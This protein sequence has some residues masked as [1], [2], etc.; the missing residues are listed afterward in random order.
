MSMHHVNIMLVYKQTE[1]RLRLTTLYYVSRDYIFSDYYI[2]D[3]MSC[4]EIMGIPLNVK[5]HVICWIHYFFDYI[6][7]VIASLEWLASSCGKPTKT[8]D[9]LRNYLL[10]NNDSSEK[11]FARK[12]DCLFKTVETHKFKK[13]S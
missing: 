4:L 8:M 7:G 13:K 5:F 12:R 11:N 6:Y 3:S 2:L 9:V 1:T 10:H